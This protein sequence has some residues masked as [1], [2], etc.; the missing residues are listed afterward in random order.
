MYGCEAE[1]PHDWRF[2]MMSSDCSSSPHSAEQYQEFWVM[3][4]CILRATWS[5]RELHRGEDPLRRLPGALSGSR[6]AAR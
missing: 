3:C 4:V 6:G 2:M 5:F 1:C